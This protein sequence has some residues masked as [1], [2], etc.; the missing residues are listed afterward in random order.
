MDYLK[1]DNCA[2]GPAEWQPRYNAMRNALLKYW[3]QPILYALC[4]W[5]ED[6]VWKWGNETGHSWRI[7]FDIWP[8]P[9]PPLSPVYPLYR[10]IVFVLCVFEIRRWMTTHVC[11]SWE[12]IVYIAEIQARTWMYSGPYGYGDMDMLGIP[13]H[14]PL[15]PRPLIRP[16]F[17][18]FLGGE[19]VKLEAGC[20]SGY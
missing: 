3:K 15:L 19:F 18:I 5:G 9:P 20:D 14:L 12:R 13:S 2:R 4:E 16:P 11:R 17:R 1:Y 8:Y 10:S 6:D 7:S